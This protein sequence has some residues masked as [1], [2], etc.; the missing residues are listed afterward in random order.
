MDPDGHGGY[1]A[2]D[3]QGI[4]RFHV[5]AP[6]AWD[7]AGHFGS[8]TLNLQGASAVIQLD[9]TF[10]SQAVYPITVDPTIHFAIDYT[11][12]HLYRL[13]AVSTSDLTDG[14]SRSASYTYDPL[15]NR[16]S[17]VAG[18]TT[19]NYAYDHADRITSAGGT[20]Y[21]VNASGNLVARGTDSF[22]YDQASRLTS[23]NVSGTT[24]TSVYDGDGKRARKTVGTTTTSYVYDVGGGMPVVLDD[25]TQK[26][27]WGAGGLAY[28]VNKVSAAVAVYHTDGLGSARALSDSTGLVTQTYQT[29]EFG[30]PTLT[31]S[32]SAQPFGYT[33]EQGD[34]ESGLLYL[35]ARMYLPSIG[36]FLQ[37][38]PVRKSGSGG[39]GWN[40]YAYA[41]DNPLRFTDPAGFCTNN[42]CEQGAAGFG[43]GQPICF[44]GLPC[45]APIPAEPTPS[46]KPGLLHPCLNYENRVEA[47]QEFSG[48]VARISGP[49]GGEHCHVN[50][51][52]QGLFNY[53]IQWTGLT[54]VGGPT[55]LTGFPEIAASIVV[56][57]MANAIHDA[58][59]TVPFSNVYDWA[60]P[61]LE[62]A[63]TELTKLPPGNPFPSPD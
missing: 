9:P 11:Y 25:G 15:G 55:E 37:A 16:L 41:A 42:T 24:S 1:R 32:S 40:R 10:L 49:E 4:T 28:S 52:V 2:Q 62:E 29:D 14:T 22:G 43:Q 44:P 36:R 38:D 50:A 8:A 58:A 12:D 34:P 48:W 59:Q 47:I 6:F 61:N 13:T 46:P 7:A 30:I 57:F 51:E 56:S 45:I 5:L 17:K 23:A 18:S 54:F 63:L 53:H 31:Q 35:R 33:G 26:Y 20:S 60:L 3:S 21:T 19:T 27:I 39:L